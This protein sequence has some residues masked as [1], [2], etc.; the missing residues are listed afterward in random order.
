MTNDEIRRNDEIRMTKP[1]TAQLR[2]FDI[3]ASDFFRHSSFV[4]RHSTFGSQKCVVET[5][6]K[7]GYICSMK[8]LWAFAVWIGMGTILGVGI[9]MAVKG[10]PLLLIAAF[11]GFV[12]AVGRIGCATH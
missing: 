2:V 1:A 3:R 9:L 10:S 6:E 5:Q 7:A 11:I 12:I 4:I 8:L